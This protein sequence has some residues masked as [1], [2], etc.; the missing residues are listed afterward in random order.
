MGAWEVLEHT[1]NVG[2]RAYGKDAARLFENAAAGMLAIAFEPATVGE[3]EQRAISAT[4][5]DREMLLVNFLDELLWLIDGEHW[6]PRRVAV[7]EILGTHISATAFGEA[8]DPT[9]HVMRTII[10]AVTFHL[11][12]IRQGRDRWEAEV[13]FDI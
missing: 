8:R 9:R 3:R 4:A 11:L 5:P 1:A 2:I 6:L 10:K 12:A 13:Y 7:G